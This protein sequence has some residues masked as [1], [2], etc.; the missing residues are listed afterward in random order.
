MHRSRLRK[1]ILLL[2]SFALP[3]LMWYS[4]G[5]IF[6]LPADAVEQGSKRTIDFHSATSLGAL[7]GVRIIR[8]VAYATWKDRTMLGAAVGKVTV[9]LP[10]NSM[11][12]FDPNRRLLD[13][14]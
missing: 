4:A 2:C 11:L 6:F 8:G 5:F 12:C 9:D 10:P 7:Y 13:N 14:C 1:F 3:I